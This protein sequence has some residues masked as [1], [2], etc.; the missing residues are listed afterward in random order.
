MTGFLLYIV[1]FLVVGTIAYYID[2]KMGMKWYRGLYKLTHKDPLPESVARGFVVG[3]SAG[4]RIGTAVTIAIAASTLHFLVGSPS[5]LTLFWQTAV[6]SVA[7]LV[8]FSVGA[9]A[10]H[11]WDP[12]AKAAS[13]M[14]TLDGIESGAID[15]VQKAQ[16]ALRSGRDEVVKKAHEVA[17]EIRNMNTEPESPTAAPQSAAA[18]TAPVSA[19]AAE[20][21]SDEKATKPA[22]KTFADVL[23]RYRRGG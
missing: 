18:D 20:G 17:E 4:E 12:E 3:R 5:L 2:A 15:P 16:D 21:Q 8:G 14:K 6:Q 23:E 22:S 10:H 11:K 9:F 7:V 1:T 19:E 13:L